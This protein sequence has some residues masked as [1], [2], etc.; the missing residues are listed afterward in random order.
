MN[1]HDLETGARCTRCGELLPAPI[2]ALPVVH[3]RDSEVLPTC[4]TVCLAGLVAD[5]AGRIREPSTGKSNGTL[6]AGVCPV[7]TATAGR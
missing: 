2:E 6:M 1:I 3:G 4:S 5:L 7:C